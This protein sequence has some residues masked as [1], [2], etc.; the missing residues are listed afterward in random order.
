MPYLVRQRELRMEQR[1]AVRG[2]HLPLHGRHL[3]RH[4]AGNPGRL[5]LYHLLLPETLLQK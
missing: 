1:G 2:L 4:L 5:R 3:G